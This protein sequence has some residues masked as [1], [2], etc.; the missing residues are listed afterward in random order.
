MELHYREN[1]NVKYATLMHI[2]CLLP[3]SLKLN[4]IEVGKLDQINADPK[5]IW[6]RLA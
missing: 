5:E 2:K 4:S 1:L 6:Y 3:V